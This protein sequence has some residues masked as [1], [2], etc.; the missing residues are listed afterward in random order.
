MP[1]GEPPPLPPFDASTPHHLRHPPSPCGGLRIESECPPSVLSDGYAAQSTSSPSRYSTSVGQRDDIPPPSAAAC[2]ALRAFTSTSALSRSASTTTFWFA[3]IGT[4][5]QLQMILRNRRSRGRW[6]VRQ[7]AMRCRIW[8]RGRGSERGGG[9][10][11]G[12][13]G[14]IR[15][16][17][18]GSLGLKAGA[19]GEVGTKRGGGRGGALCA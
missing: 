13:R 9:L 16:K 2:T 4:P 17:G 18:S 5:S 10:G 1:H 11:L 8:R 19:K 12:E 7:L 6:N 3:R 15:E 14:R